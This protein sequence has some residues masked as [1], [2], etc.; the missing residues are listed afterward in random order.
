MGSIYI[1]ILGYK[2]LLYEYDFKTLNID[3]ITPE[4]SFTNSYTEEW[5]K[6]KNIHNSNKWLRIILDSKYKKANLNKVI[7]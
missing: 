2:L 7:K 6:L 3:N 5:F 4:E 1:F